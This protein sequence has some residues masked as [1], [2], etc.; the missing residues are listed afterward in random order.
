MVKRMC[1]GVGIDRSESESASKEVKST[2]TTS[3]E[4]R[5]NMESL[6]ATLPKPKN[7][8]RKRQRENDDSDE[9]SRKESKRQTEE[10]ETKEDRIPLNPFLDDAKALKAEEAPQDYTVVYQTAQHEVKEDSAGVEAAPVYGY[11]SDNTYEVQG[12][13]GGGY[14]QKQYEAFMRRSGMLAAASAKTAK[15]ANLLV[16]VNDDREL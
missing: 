11:A 2:V 6:F 16:G 1:A 9:D 12:G 15:E 7:A 14:S 5:P 4:K 13:Y 3:K 10:A 8:D